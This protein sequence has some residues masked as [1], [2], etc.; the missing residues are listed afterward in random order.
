MPCHIKIQCQ[1]YPTPLRNSKPNPRVAIPLFDL[2]L[3]LRN[4]TLAVYEALTHESY[5][6]LLDDQV[7]LAVDLNCQAYKEKLIQFCKQASSSEVADRTTVFMCVT[8]Q[9]DLL[10]VGHGRGSSIFYTNLVDIMT[11]GDMP[12]FC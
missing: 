8:C 2:P 7:H 12:T 3:A 11:T 10:F 1:R 6:N 5:G 9:T 4:D